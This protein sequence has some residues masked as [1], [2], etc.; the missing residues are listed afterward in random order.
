[1]NNNIFSFIRRYWLL[2]LA[3]VAFVA[4]VYSD[5]AF[6]ALGAM[7]YGP[8]LFFLAIVCALL[9][10]HWFFG[11]SL[12]A[13]AHSGAFVEFW[14]KN[15]SASERVKLNLFVVCVF[16]LSAAIIFAALAK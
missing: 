12:D 2:L 5:K 13:D 10:R 6:G 3:A 7:V 1:M 4:L 11:N 9:A 16:V 8:A 14:I 15:L